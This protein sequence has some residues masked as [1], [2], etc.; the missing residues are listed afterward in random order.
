[1]VYVRVTPLGGVLFVLR[2]KPLS[3]F[4]AVWDGILCQ[5]FGYLLISLVGF[6]FE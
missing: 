5:F 6:T 4:S 2:T 3:W 1:M